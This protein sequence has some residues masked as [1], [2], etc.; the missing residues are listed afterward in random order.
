MAGGASTCATSAKKF[1]SPSWA[2]LPN[3]H[4]VSGR[5]GLESNREEDHLLAGIRL[6]ETYRVERR[7]H[8]PYIRPLRLGV[9]QA[10]ARPGHAQ[11]VAEGAQ[12]RIGTPGDFDRLVDHP[13][14]G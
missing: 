10:A 13:R 12:N 4:G 14:P 3:R 5:G 8:D 6:R 9:E 1:E 2:C 11:H 7:I